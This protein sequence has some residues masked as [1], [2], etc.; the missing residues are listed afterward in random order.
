MYG[1]DVPDEILKARHKNWRKTFIK[2]FNDHNRPSGKE[3][4][5]W[6]HEGRYPDPSETGQPGPWDPWR[7]PQSWEEV[8]QLLTAH[9]TWVPTK[10]WTPPTERK[11]GDPPIP[12]W[13]WKMHEAMWTIKNQPRG[14]METTSSVDG[15]FGEVFTVTDYGKFGDTIMKINPYTGESAGHVPKRWE[16]VKQSRYYGKD[17]PEDLKKEKHERYGVVGVHRADEPRVKRVGTIEGD[18]GEFKGRHISG[19]TPYAIPVEVGGDEDPGKGPWTVKGRKGQ[20]ITSKKRMV[21]AYHDWAVQKESEPTPDPDQTPEQPTTHH[22]S[23]WNPYTPHTTAEMTDVQRY[24]YLQHGKVVDAAGVSQSDF[25]DFAYTA[26]GS[27]ALREDVALQKRL[28]LPEHVRAVMSSSGVVHT[29][30]D[31]TEIPKYIGMHD[32]VQPPQKTVLIH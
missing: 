32:V 7:Q 2:M 26:S 11:M 24:M 1:Y 30:F 16:H 18:H 9:P 17:T 10:K 19:W 22:Q 29:V 13:A 23:E 31:Q 15:G 21:E 20:W 12:N 27:L 5:D 6:L 8:L 4:Y 28:N 3:P 25:P 14:H